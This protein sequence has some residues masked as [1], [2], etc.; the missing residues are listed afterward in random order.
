[1]ERSF[2]YQNA[3]YKDAYSRINGLVIEGEL[4]AVSNYER[5]AE[6]LPQDAATLKKLAAMEN[7]HRA[8][9]VACGRNLAVEADMDFA[10][11]FFQTLEDNF[12]VAADQGDIPTCL[13]I[14]SLIIECFAIS[15]YNT[16]IPVADDFARKIT[17][18]VVKDEYL[19]LHYGETYLRE[20][21]STDKATIEAAN[22]QNLPVVWRMLN[23]VTDDAEVLGMAREEIVEDFLIAYGGALGEIGFTTREV[24]KL[25]AH[26]LRG[27]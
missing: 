12:R 24:L 5:L 7:R 27:S 16:Y 26:G 11:K 25:S 18:G 10:K 17:E 22:A 13:V 8:G 1:M 21:F 14:Q 3:D 20:H 2:D 15:A 4:Q 23:E 6:L 9:F 19:H